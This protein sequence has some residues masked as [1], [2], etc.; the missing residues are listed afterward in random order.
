M[1]DID[2]LTIEYILKSSAEPH[3][4]TIVANGKKCRPLTARQILE[5]HHA[6]NVISDATKVLTAR[7]SRG[8]W[9]WILRNT[10]VRYF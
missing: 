4:Y 10:E 1:I 2:G 5:Y 8:Q 7:L 6:Q 3:M 9:H